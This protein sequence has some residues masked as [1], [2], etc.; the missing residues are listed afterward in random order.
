ME[1]KFYW[2]ADFSRRLK[3]QRF[4]IEFTTN[5]RTTPKELIL[6]LITSL[7]SNGYV[8]IGNCKLEEVKDERPQSDS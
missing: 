5:G 1:Q 7:A 8:F 2:S 6:T 3:I 4:G